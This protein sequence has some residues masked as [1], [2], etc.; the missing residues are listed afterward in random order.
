MKKFIPSG[1]QLV[2]GIVVA[3]AAIFV[4]NKVPA[5]RRLVGPSA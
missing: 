3:L 2:S 5:I 1:P 4:V